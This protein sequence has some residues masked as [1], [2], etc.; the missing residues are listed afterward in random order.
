[1]TE[2][3]KSGTPPAI[4]TA[5]LRKAFGPAEAVA[6]LTLRVEAG[7]LFGLVG[8]D[9][10]GKSTAIRLL[11]GLLRADGGSARVLGL[12][13]PRQSE[14]V[15]RRIGYL[16]QDF[17]LYGDL[18]VDENIEFF[19]RIHGVRDFSARRTELLNV[20]R[21][22]P[23]RTRLAQN[24]SGGMKKKLALACTLIHTPGLIFLDEPSTGVDPVSRGEFWN[25]LSGVLEQ[26]VTILLT[27]PYLDEA[28]R[29]HR[30]AL[31]HRG[32]IVQSGS[33]GEIKAS[34]PGVLYEI[35]CAAPAAAYRALRAHWSAT[36][37]V[38]LGD[39][40]RVRCDD[41]VCDPQRLQE[42]CAGPGVRATR[43][44]RVDAG[45]EDAFV[46]LVERMEREEASA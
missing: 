22:G 11:C 44:E 27:S 12:E 20:T 10:A 29:C 2:A 32:R 36:Q 33:P 25:I 42:Q 15:K 45:L 16:S 3:A 24:L 21:L 46:A 8:P 6:D 18:T 19:A 7:T 23:F 40:L 14:A 35:T 1:M 34:M 28:D 30:V 37:V 9:G 31:M 39:R 41:G 26:G 4:E 17:T 13:L 43:V 38:L 5:G